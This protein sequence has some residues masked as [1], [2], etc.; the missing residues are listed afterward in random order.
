MKIHHQSLEFRNHTFTYLHDLNQVKYKY[1]IQDY[2][3]TSASVPN[4]MCPPSEYLYMP[5]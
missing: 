2:F 5:N 4:L 1:K 3:S